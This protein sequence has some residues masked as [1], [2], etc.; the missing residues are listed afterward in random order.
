MSDCQPILELMMGLMDG[1]LSPDEKVRVHDHL[2]RC[3]RCRGEYE[4]LRD[5]SGLLRE[6]PALAEP[7]DEVLRDLWQSPY[8]RLTRSAGWAMVIAGVAVLGLYAAYEL[9]T[10]AELNLPTLAAVS[11]WVGLAI[12][13]F[14]VLRERLR[15]YESDPYKEVER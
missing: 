4:Q 8:S 5:I 1:E 9:F 15:T 7:Q 2:R 11:I 3:A 6:L 10:K 12:L 13:F 14:S